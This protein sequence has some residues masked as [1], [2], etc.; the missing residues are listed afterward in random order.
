MSKE[1]I[2]SLTMKAHGKFSA[3]MKPIKTTRSN[4]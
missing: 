3:D 4:Y 2:A 1:R